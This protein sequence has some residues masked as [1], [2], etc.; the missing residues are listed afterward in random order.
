MRGGGP[1]G[2]LQGHTDL[3]R[4]IEA[5]L[6]GREVA[7]LLKMHILAWCGGQRRIFRHEALHQI[8]PVFEKRLNLLTAQAQ[9]P[10]SQTYKK[11]NGNEI[12]NHSTS[13]IVLFEEETH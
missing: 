1:F 12:D 2:L 10:R 3:V 9:Y 7:V 5:V 8:V 13:G 4:H 11:N 6:E